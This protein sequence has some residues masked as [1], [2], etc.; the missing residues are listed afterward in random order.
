[1]YVIFKIVCFCV[2][3]LASSEWKTGLSASK[4][5]LPA[6]TVHPGNEHH[7]SLHQSLRDGYY[8]SPFLP[9][10][11]VRGLPFS[12]FLQVNIHSSALCLSVCLSGELS[13]GEVD[14]APVL[15]NL[16]SWVFPACVKWTVSFP[17][18]LCCWQEWPCREPWLCVGR[19]V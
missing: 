2:S 4:R 17:H 12:S 13:E 15:K 3:V 18:P 9:S 11:L 7:S 8:L 16:I 14:N 6:F 5:P 1:M 10:P 19:T